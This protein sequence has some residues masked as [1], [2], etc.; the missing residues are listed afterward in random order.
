MT[1]SFAVDEMACAL[2]IHLKFGSTITATTNHS[3]SLPADQAPTNDTQNKKKPKQQQQKSQ[4]NTKKPTDTKAK[5]PAYDRWTLQDETTLDYGYYRGVARGQGSIDA[6]R[7]VGEYYYI[8]TAINYTNGP[9][10]MGHAYEATTADAI[11]RYHRLT[12]SHAGGVWFV[13]GTDEHGQKIATTA[14]DRQKAPI[15]IC[16][17]YSTGFRVLNQRLLISN[18]DYIR[19]TMD[20]HKKTAQALWKLCQDDIYLDTYTGWYNVKEETFVT[21]NDAQLWEYKDPTTGIPLKKVDEESYF[22]KMSKYQQRLIQYIQTDNPTFIQPEMHKNSILQRL[23]SEEL[24]DLSI[25]RT[26]FD[27]GV[28]VPEGFNS[29]HV[30]YVWVDA[31]SNYLTGVDALQIVNDATKKEGLHHFWPANNH[32]IGKDILWF[33]TVIWPTLLM[34]ANLPL[35]KTVFA[36]GFVNDKDGKKMSKSLGNVVDP[37]DM[38]DQFDVDSFRWYLCKEAPYGGELSFSPDSMLDMHNAD[39]C[40]NIGNCVNR[41]TSLC[42]RFCPDGKIPD[43]PPPERPPL[44]DWTSRLESYQAKMNAH[45]LQAGCQIAAKGFSDING[46]LQEEAPWAKS[47]DEHAVYRQSVVRGA[48]EAIYALAHLLL[49][50][51]PVSGKKIFQKLATEPVTLVDL[52]KNG[53][54]LNNLKVGTQIEI[55]GAVLYDKLLS[56][57]EKK[58]ASAKKKD[59]YAESKRK[60]EEAKAKARAQAA[61]ASGANVDPDFTKLDIRVGQIVEVWHHETADKLFCE[62]INVGE[63]EED[64]S[65]KLR[66]IAS[67]LRE[68]YSLEDMKDRK[69]LVLC[70]LKPQKM[71]GF[72]SNGMVLAAAT[73]GKTLVELVAPPEG[74][75]LGER[76]TIADLT[77]EPWS[78]AQVKKRKVLEAVMAAGWKINDH[79]IATWKEG[80]METKAGPCRVSSPKLY[81]AKIS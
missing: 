52:K 65:P 13:T 79:G 42:K 7:P 32:V 43:V 37:H 46:W 50:F 61:A 63:T 12:G 73:E 60:K 59:D 20:R 75:E 58:A 38:L 62:K 9:A 57:E 23:Q 34:S 71:L 8:T 51:L 11:A 64:G 49:P 28:P 76:V 3:H 41:A 69:V 17:L 81:N 2:Q 56:E 53:N 22:F 78:A 31:L 47:G 21:D 25:S 24:R 14:A 48:L 16:N 74:A 39:L 30:M 45:E 10:H 29:N 6:S 5:K 4:T 26:T 36:H 80:V 54:A 67:G 1:D 44:A 33:H 55:D 35:P 70:N 15:D 72:E 68:H 66:Q 77:G 19:T 18:D 27:W 40:D